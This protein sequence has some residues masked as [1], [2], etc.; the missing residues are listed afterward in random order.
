[1][2]DTTRSVQD[3]VVSHDS[4]VTRI[5]AVLRKAQA[6]GWKD[7][8]LSDVS[9]VPVRTIRSYRVEGKEPSLSNALSLFFVLG[10]KATNP[11]LGLIGCKAVLIDAQDE[12]QSLS[13]RIAATLQSLSIIATA[14]ADGRIDHLEAPACEDAADAIISQLIALSSLGKRK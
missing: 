12:Q 13:E 9:G 14:A 11:L 4:V 10:D 2:L 6:D 5:Q 8:D 1:M 3:S 7:D